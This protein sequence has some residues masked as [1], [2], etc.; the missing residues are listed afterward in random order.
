MTSGTSFSLHG[1]VFINKRSL[2]VSV[3]FDATGIC[4]SRQPRLFE[5]KAAMWVMT[6]AATHRAFKDFVM[7]RHVELRLHF[8]VAACAEFRI[9]GAQHA[10][11]CEPRLLRIRGRHVIVRTCQ[12]STG[13]G[14]VR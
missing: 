10:S 9:V 6:I 14:A 4:A 8:V 11:C 7:E 1:R 5:L 2:L 12:V 3:A 13:S